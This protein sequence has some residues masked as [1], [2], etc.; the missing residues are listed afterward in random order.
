MTIRDIREAL[1]SGKITR[2]SLMRSIRE[3]DAADMKAAFS[4]KAWKPIGFSVF[5]APEKERPHYTQAARVGMSYRD[6]AAL[7]SSIA[8]FVLVMLGVGVVLYRLNWSFSGEQT[9]EI[10]GVVAGGLAFYLG[11]GLTRYLWTAMAL[12]G[13]FYA[14]VANIPEIGVAMVK[15]GIFVC[16]GLTAVPIV[17]A[18]GV[19]AGVAFDYAYRA[20]HYD[21]KDTG[22]EKK[23]RE[24]P[25]YDGY[26]WMF[27]KVWEQRRLLRNTLAERN[28]KR[29][30]RK[31]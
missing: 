12:A 23:P 30:G 18:L 21:P 25:P 6:A 19:L 14:V 3:E 7:I 5:I 13:G 22:P 28:R 4:V 16:A 15:S 20:A 8:L 27:W 9:S 2:F 26:P 10:A 17:R 1:I 24:K 31:D 29:S 11:L